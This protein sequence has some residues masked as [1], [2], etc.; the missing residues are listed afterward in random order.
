MIIVI[1]ACLLDTVKDLAGDAVAILE[2]Y[3]IKSA[4]IVGHSM[5]GSV[6]QLLAIYHPEKVLSIISMCVGIVGK[7]CQPPKEVMDVLLENKPTGDFEKDLDGF[8]RS[9]KILNGDFKVDKEMATKYTKDFYKR[10]I[11]YVGVAWNHIKCQE[12][13]SE[14]SK[15]LNKIKA[16]AL[17]V[18]GEKDPLMPQEQVEINAED[19]ESSKFIVIPGMGHMFFNKEVEKTISKIILKYLKD[20]FC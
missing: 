10:S 15:D 20:S 18:A 14:H 6:A 11:H 16:P 1:K 2:N 17:F 5:G 12:N 8:M 19:V 7:G 13:V 4:N 3:K 9:W